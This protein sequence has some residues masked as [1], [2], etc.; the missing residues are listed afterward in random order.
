M[1]NA[2]RHLLCST[3]CQHNQWILGL[4]DIILCHSLQLRISYLVSVQASPSLDIYKIKANVKC[5]EFC[6]LL[7]MFI[8]HSIRKYC[9]PHKHVHIR[10]KKGTSKK[11]QV[12]LATF[13]T[14]SFTLGLHFTHSATKS[15]IQ[16]A[17]LGA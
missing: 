12:S 7:T 8:L 2:F 10:C 3:L 4:V 6:L 14:F 11:L 13:S 15:N 17:N 5:L 1:F 16:K 9:Q